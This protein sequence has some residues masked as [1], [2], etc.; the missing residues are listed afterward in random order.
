LYQWIKQYYDEGLYTDSDVQ[1]FVDAQWITQTECEQ[2]IN[3][4]G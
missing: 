1:I 3:Q 4:T 2:I